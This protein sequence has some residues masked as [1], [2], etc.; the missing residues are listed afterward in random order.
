MPT[1]RKRV[2][3]QPKSLA[4][5]A[6]DEI[7]LLEEF[8]E[9]K[10][11]ALNAFNRQQTAAKKAVAEALN[12]SGHGEDGVLVIEG[13]AYQNGVATSYTFES[14]TWYGLFN[15]LDITEEQFIQGI[16][17]SKTEAVKIIGED[18][19]LSLQI[20]KKGTAASVRT[21]DMKPGFAKT[22]VHIYNIHKPKPPK[23]K[24]GKT[25]G[26]SRRKIRV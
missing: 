20:P 4:Q 22:G 18:R 15:D 10:K 6:A 8:A 13:I 25:S 16:S 24:K 1:K 11:D 12:K 2:T 3:K 7:K 21:V 5:I 23:P 9:S 26:K 14:E 17:V 19:V